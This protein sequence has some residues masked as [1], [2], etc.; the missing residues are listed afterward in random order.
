MSIQ[1][2]GLEDIWGP[3]VPFKKWVAFSYFKCD[4]VA[5]RLVLVI[6]Y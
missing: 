1:F 6:A 3:G 4:R 5:T 2:F